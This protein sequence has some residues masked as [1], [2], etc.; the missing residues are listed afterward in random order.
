MSRLKQEMLTMEQ[1]E[2]SYDAQDIAWEIYK[3]SRQYEI[4]HPAPKGAPIVYSCDTAFNWGEET[5]EIFQPIF[6]KK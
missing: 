6:D 2:D 3:T 5:T 1:I 4:D